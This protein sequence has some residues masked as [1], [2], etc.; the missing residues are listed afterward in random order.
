MFVAYRYRADNERSAGKIRQA[1]AVLI[2]V[3]AAA[4]SAANAVGIGSVNITNGIVDIHPG[5]TRYGYK[6]AVG[7][8][9]EH[10]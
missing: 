9:G 7:F 1:Q 3:R 2:A 8:A 5:I 4:A 10:C 6:S